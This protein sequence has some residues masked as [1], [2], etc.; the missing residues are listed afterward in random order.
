MEPHVDPVKDGPPPEE[1]FRTLAPAEK[2][3]WLDSSADDHE[4]SRF[5][6]LAWDP[7]ATL[8]WRADGH[9]ARLTLED[10]RDTLSLGHDPF[11][12]LEALLHASRSG[13]SRARPAPF[14]GGIIGYLGY[15][16]GGCLERLPPHPPLDLGFPGLQMRCYNIVYIY[17]HRRARASL[18]VG[19]VD[20]LPARR[21]SAYVERVR[22]VVGERL[23]SAKT[24]RLIAGTGRDDTQ[25]ATGTDLRP[26]DADRESGAGRRVEA[27]LA[28]DAGGAL[29]GIESDVSP[30]DYRTMVAAARDYIARGDI[31]QVNVSQRFRGPVAGRPRELYLRLRRRHPAPF[32]AY[33]T[34]GTDRAV[35]SVSPELFLSL[36]GRRVETRPIKGTTARREDPAQDRAARAALV[37]SPKDRAELTMIVDLERN[38]LGRVCEFGSVKV[39][40][41]AA[42]ESFATVHH[43]VATVVGTLQ[44][45]LDIVDLLRAGFPSGSVTGAPKIRAM[46]IIAEL[47]RTARSVYTGSVGWIGWDGA[48]QFN[49]AIRTALYSSGETVYRVGG[50]VVADSDP[51]LEYE[52]TMDKGQALYA[53]LAESAPER[54]RTAPAGKIPELRR[55]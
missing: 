46:E 48:A 22:K 3:A 42:V 6:Y 38:D 17:D 28:Q 14:R 37:R 34:A 15:E 40:T 51:L 4:L 54:N 24:R 43:L 1:L 30:A 52:E 47:E 20:G 23:Q 12:A 5:S 7:W 50:A 18:S 13:P 27:D 2:P 53:T 44:T 21:G 16:L 25:R 35:L 32:S 39:P 10:S 36:R 8:E 26:E 49:V 29:A 31:F 11:Q 41:L 9:G 19:E 55:P 45:G 33:L